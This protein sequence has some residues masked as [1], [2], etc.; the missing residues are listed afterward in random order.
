[1]S[2]KSLASVDARIAELKSELKA[3]AVYQ[4][5]AV[6]EEMRPKLA[7]I[8]NVE[9][10]PRVGGGIPRIL[11]GRKG[12]QPKGRVTQ[13]EAAEAAVRGAGH[14]LTTVEL[15]QALPAHGAVPS[16][17]NAEVNLT[18]IISKRGNLRSV[19][20]RDRRAWWL[21]DQEVPE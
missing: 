3:S 17:K 5:L 8:D 18:S 2:V 12:K 11:S 21:K 4:E 13:H 1:M 16:A 15:V 10:A 9:G 20:W 7:A 14:P 6:L 19:R